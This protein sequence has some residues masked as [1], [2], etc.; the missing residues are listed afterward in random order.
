MVLSPINTLGEMV[1]KHGSV[2]CTITINNLDALF[3]K[4][5]GNR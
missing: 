3:E 5:C 4:S 1:G 2:I